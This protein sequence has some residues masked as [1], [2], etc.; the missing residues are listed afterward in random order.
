VT[1][2]GFE[3]YSIADQCDMSDDGAHLRFGDQL[4]SIFRD[5][6]VVSAL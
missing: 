1:P 6:R 5:A 4:A 3:Q 2:N